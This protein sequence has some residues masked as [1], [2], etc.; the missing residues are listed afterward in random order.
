MSSSD[1]TVF[2]FTT[3]GPLADNKQRKCLGPHQPAGSP[4]IS[5]GTRAVVVG[6]R[7]APGSG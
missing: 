6:P 3:K 1:Y 2:S 7:M 4:V 5:S